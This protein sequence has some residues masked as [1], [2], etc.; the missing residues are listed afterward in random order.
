[1]RGTHPTHLVVSATGSTGIR[2]LSSMP[3][4]HYDM[5]MSTERRVDAQTNIV[6]VDMAVLLI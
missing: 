4:N 3:P 5:S 1:M 2:W 6:I